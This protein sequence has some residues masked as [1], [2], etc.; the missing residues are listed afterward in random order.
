MST[1]ST[2]SSLL[3]PLLYLFYFTISPSRGQEYQSRCLVSS[4]F[5]Q[6][7]PRRNQSLFCHP[8]SSSVQF[9]GLWMIR[10]WRPRP[11]N[12]LHRAARLSRSMSQPWNPSISLGT[13]R[14]GTN[15]TLS[16]LQ[17]WFWWPWMDKDLR[18]YVQGCQECDRMEDI[19]DLNRWS[20]FLS[21]PSMHRTLTG[22]PPQNS[23]PSSVYFAINHL[24][25]LG[26]ANYRMSYLWSLVQRE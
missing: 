13:G 15:R 2:T 12:L 26:P 22:S 4:Q 24:F 9:N 18:R 20:Q 11:P 3:G 19:G 6:Q 17:D 1:E 21:W 10:S 23:L 5:P 8:T 16:L 7:N 25:S 14:P